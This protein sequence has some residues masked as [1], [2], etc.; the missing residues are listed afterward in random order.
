MALYLCSHSKKKSCNTNL[1][2]NDLL[3]MDNKCHNCYK[4]IGLSSVLLLQSDKYKDNFMTI[5]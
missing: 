2:L 1:R 5:L 4:W 3:D